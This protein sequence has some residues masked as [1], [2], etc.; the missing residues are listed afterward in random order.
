MTTAEINPPLS[1]RDGRLFIEDCD[2]AELAKTFGTPLFVVSET[3]LVENFRAYQQA[4]SRHWPEGRVRVMA[5]IKANPVTAIRR[6]LTEEGCG[7]DTFGQGELELALRGGVAPADIALNGSVKPAALIAR[8]I[9]L[10][11]HIILDSLREAELCEQEAERLGK[12]AEVVLRVKPWLAEMDVP[13]DFFPARTIRDMTQTVKYGI[14]ASDLP[15]ALEL[16]RGS[17]RLNLIGTHT[18][19]GRHSKKPEFWVSLI[20]N[21]VNLI[22]E[23]RSGMGGAWVPQL[24]SIGGGFAAEFDKESRVAVTDYRTPEA[25]SYARICTGTF[26]EELARHG[27]PADGIIFEIE[28]GRALHNDTGIHLARIENIKRETAAISRTWAETDTS[29][30][31]LSVGSLNTTSPFEYI[32]ANKAGQP[33]EN[34]AD[35]VGSTCNYECLAEQQKVPALDPGDVLAFLNTGSY[36]EPY[37]CNFNAL[38]RPGMVLVKGGEACWI[39]RPETQ[40]EVFARDIV[41]ERLAGNSRRVLGLEKNAAIPAS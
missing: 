32:I 12:T 17:Q 41:P 25:E 23:I 5:A 26:R 19:C 21:Y 13:S 30:V 24:V 9:E 20:R 37:T 31:F 6:I 1:I 40:D 22:N 10:G 4:F 18:H 27:I 38:P 29:E 8:A 36:I 28:P 7:C 33:A 16:L 15:K 3:K 34:T 14:P 2:A 39:K 35:I 11:V